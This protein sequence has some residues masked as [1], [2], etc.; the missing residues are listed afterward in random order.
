MPNFL[1]PTDIFRRRK[2][3]GRNRD[4]A[5]ATLPCGCQELDVT[6]PMKGPHLPHLCHAPHVLTACHQEGPEIR[7][8]AGPSLMDQ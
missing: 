1:S 6:T 4:G 8:Q 7:K 2:N 5:E 3:E